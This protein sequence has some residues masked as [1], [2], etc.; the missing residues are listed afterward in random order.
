MLLI[1]FQIQWIG[2]LRVIRRI[3]VSKKLKDLLASVD[4][5]YQL[6][7]SCSENDPEIV[8]ISFN[9]K[10]VEKSSMFVCLVGEN[11][12]AHDFA[13]DAVENGA[14]VIL[15]QKK[16]EGITVPVVIVENTAMAMALLST[17]L[18]DFPSSKLN[19]IGVTGTNGKTTVTHLVEKILE[20]AGKQCGLIG[21]LGNRLKSQDVYKETKHTTPQSPDLQEYLAQAVEDKID[22]VVMEVSSHAL[23]LYRVLGC[24]FSVALLT[25]VTQDHLDFHVTMDNYAQAKLKLFKQ[26]APSSV[27]KKYAIVN[28]DDPLASKFEKAVAE[29]VNFL[30]Y[31]VNDGADI[32]A[33]DIKYSQGGTSFTCITPMGNIEIELKLKGLFSVYNA[34]SAI[35]IAVAENIPLEIVK[36]ALFGVENIPGRFEA[37][38]DRPL[39]IVDYAHTPDGLSNILDAARKLVSGTGQLVTV[40]GCGGDRDPTKRPKMANIVESLSDKIFVTSD[41]PRTED[42]QQIISDILTGI[43]NFDSGHVKVEIDRAIAIE[44]AINS[45][46]DDDVVVIAGKGHE[47][48]QILA[49]R[50]IHFDDR[51]VVRDILSK[52]N[53]AK[54]GS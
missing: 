34:L 20:T 21:T 18:Y 51:E 7:S 32:R 50:T 37:V 17:A 47:D 16:L 44:M 12:D 3:D 30:S 22:Y 48:Y 54:A 1:Q 15:A 11:F 25:N 52:T 38:S 4:L 14:S 2:S 29:G 49:D 41:N 40:F 5:S 46:N 9:S 6:D 27:R 10:Q 23:D 36:K 24:D 33:V 42:P 39:V 45:A 13:H 43:K 31:G 35:S 28:L 26:L 8:S 19:L 53:V